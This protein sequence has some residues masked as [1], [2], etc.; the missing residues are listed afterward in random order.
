MPEVD[1]ESGKS[2]VKYEVSR[3]IERFGWIASTH[4]KTV[5]FGSAI[6]LKVDRLL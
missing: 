6:L 5:K 4:I 1:K 3:Y 2:Y